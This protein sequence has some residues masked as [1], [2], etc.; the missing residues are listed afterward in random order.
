MNTHRSRW[1]QAQLPTMTDKTV[2]V[3]GGASGIGFQAARALAGCGARVVVLGRDGAKGNAAVAQ[4]KGRS[5]GAIVEFQ[6]VDL[7]SLASIEAFSQG[8]LASG[9]P[10]HL[11]LNVAGVMAVPRREATPDGF[12][13][14]MGTNFL[15]HFALTGRLLPALRSGNARVVTVSAAVGRWKMARL[16]PDD[17]QAER[18][19]YSPMGAYARSKLA[20]IMFAVELQRHAKDWG[21]TSVA[22]DPG[23]AVTNL[24][25]HASGVSGAVGTLLSTAMGYPWSAWRRTRSSPRSCRCPPRAPSLVLLR[26]TSS[27]VARRLETSASHRSRR[28]RAFAKPCGRRPRR[29]PA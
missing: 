6:Q 23:T 5:P 14:H 24:Q 29:S 27:N 21:V 3:T 10:I 16:D 12:E 4:I 11:L 7:G 17:L 8:W 22:V 20:G 28:T 25:R 18:R 1:T 2:L 19:K 13:M 15:G 26:G 9:E